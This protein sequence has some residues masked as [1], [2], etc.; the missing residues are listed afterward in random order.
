MIGSGGGH[1]AGDVHE[2]VVAE[3]QRRRVV[4]RV[5]TVGGAAQAVVHADGRGRLHGQDGIVAAGV[6]G[7]RRRRRR[8][9][10]AGGVAEGLLRPVPLSTTSKVMPTADVKLLVLRASVT[11]PRLTDPL[12]T[13][14]PNWTEPVPAKVLTRVEVPSALGTKLPVT[15]SVLVSVAAVAPSGSRVADQGKSAESRGILSDCTPHTGLPRLL[16]QGQ[17]TRMSIMPPSPAFGQVR[18]T[19]PWIP[20]TSD[21][22]STNS[23]SVL[24][25]SV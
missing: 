13:T 6:G 4:G 1:A 15:S 20:A 17:T 11:L 14:W 7:R 25:T 10:R 5:G 3:D 18:R 12:A 24:K 16:H 19:L 22:P 2:S 21:C 9:C 8:P 23:S